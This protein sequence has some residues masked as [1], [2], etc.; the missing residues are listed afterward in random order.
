MRREVRYAHVGDLSIA[1]EVLG[2]AGPDLLFV[3]GFV[4]HL[5]LAWQ[6]PSLARFLRG[7][8]SFSRLTWFDKRGTGLSDPSVGPATV[9]D[10]LADI[11][12]VLDAVGAERATLF[13]VAVGAGLCT[14]FALREPERVRSLVLWAAHARLLATHDYPA[15]W[16]E[17]F[18]AAALAGIDASWATGSGIE[19]MNPT[20]AGDE[21]FRDWFI[22]H[23]R[24]AASPAQA[25]ELFH[26]CAES[27]LRPMLGEVDVPTLL[28][29][30]TDDPWLSVDHSRYVAANIPG[31]RLV[32]LPGVDHW[33]WIGDGQAVLAEIQ[34]FVT[35]TRPRRRDRPAFGPESLTRREREVCGLAMQGLTARVIGERLSI[36]E[37]TA[38]RHVANAYAKLGIGSRVELVRRAGEFGL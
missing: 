11:R 19:A 17:E 24:A 25:R 7:L 35:G 9:E 31:A 22:R 3:P 27:D 26:L 37:R 28:L 13:G 12:A 16:T 10:A 23:A 38:E 29:H 18:Y 4:S 30:H 32:E 5:D 21:R 34:E 1:Y 36:S 20:A 2:G 33:P 6:E 15:G 8:A 14:S